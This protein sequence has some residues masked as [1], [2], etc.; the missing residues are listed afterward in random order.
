MLLWP[1]RLMSEIPCRDA[2]DLDTDFAPEVT[3]GLPDSTEVIVDSG[4]LDC[5]LLQHR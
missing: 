5:I 1:G 2:A 4:A 3:F